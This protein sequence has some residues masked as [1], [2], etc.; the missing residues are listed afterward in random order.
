L[1]SS[2]LTGSFMPEL[3]RSWSSALVALRLLRGRRKK[4]WLWPILALAVA[5]CSSTPSPVA[6]GCTGDEQ[7]AATQGVCR[8][9]GP[10]CADGSSLTPYFCP[11]G[12]LSDAPQDCQC[13]SQSYY[14][15]SGQVL[16]C[17]PHP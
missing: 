9:A 2:L 7:L 12:V 17:C 11:A 4:K 6:A 16:C 8:P 10:G 3:S 5:G 14:A 15:P 13:C 1:V